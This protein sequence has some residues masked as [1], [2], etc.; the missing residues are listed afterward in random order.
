MS[1]KF[2]R[3][4][5]LLKD[6]SEMPRLTTGNADLDS[7]LGGGIEP[8]HFYLFYGDNDRSTDLL[9]HQLLVNCLLPKEKHGF[10]G[11]SVYSNCGNYREEKT[12]FD[13]HLLTF[14]IKAA[15]L[16]PVKAMDDIYVIRAFSEEQQEKTVNDVQRLLKEDRE[17]KLIVV[18]NIAKLFTSKVSTSGKSLTERRNKLQKV[19]IKLW[20]SCAQNNA[21]FIASC[22]PNKTA[23]SGIPQPEGGKYL[24]HEAN[25][26]V[27]LKK[28]REKGSFV[29]A[30]L[31]K[32]PN[33]SPRKVDCDFTIGGNV[34]D[35]I[36]IP[37]NIL[38]K[39][40][41]NRL[42][43]GY[44]EA[45][46]DAS[47]RD[48][49]DRLLKAWSSEREAMNYA[50][51]PTVLDVMLLT[52]LVDNRKLI[53]TLFDQVNVIDLNLDRIKAY[54]ERVVD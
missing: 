20:Q 8:G 33:R 32:H 29:T 9:I 37:V 7:L 35:G 5:D 14:L 19:V 51:V 26:I 50:K 10:D 11:K 31:L 25:V 22:R 27:Y 44:R 13:S 34:R 42:K 38:L 53:E 24:R 46:M 2:R 45:L 28:R 12:L 43:R 47:R 36:T 3:G 18:H 16:D 49:F 15:K 48:S 54:R 1:V 4:L 40:E 39:E 21:A 6:R 23:R 17:I 52:G 30:Y 41:M